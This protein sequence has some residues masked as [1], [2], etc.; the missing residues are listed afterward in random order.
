VGGG[1]E[2]PLTGDEAPLDGV[3]QFA[4]VS[5]PSV[6]PQQLTG[7][8]TERDI[9]LGHFWRECPDESLGEEQHVVPSFPEGR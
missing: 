2:T 7:V 8:S 9:S 4:D 3:L 1:D 5:R 6:P